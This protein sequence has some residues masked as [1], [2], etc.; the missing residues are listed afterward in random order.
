MQPNMTNV[1]NFPFVFMLTRRLE[2]DEFIDTQAADKRNITQFGTSEQ[3]AQVVVY[4][5]INCSA[6]CDVGVYG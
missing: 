5:G 4:T 1:Y 6:V 2:K 3:A